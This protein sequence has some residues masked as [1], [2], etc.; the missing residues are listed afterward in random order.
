MMNKHGNQSIAAE[1]GKTLLL[2]MLLALL[3]NWFNPK[4]IPLIR[5]VLQK[6]AVADSVLFGTTLPAR[7]Q[8]REKEQD[9]TKEESAQSDRI[10][11]IAPL[12]Q[13]ALSNLDSMKKVVAI[14]KGDELPII[15]FSQLKRLID[16]HHG[17]LIDARN[18]DEYARGYIEGARNVPYLEVEQHFEEL[19]QIPQ[20]TLVIIYCNNP[21]CPLGRSLLSFMKQMDF[22][23]LILFDGGYD[24][25]EK[26]MKK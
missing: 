24:A 25:W 22:K 3:Y 8:T 16:M 19:T 20:D 21:E 11:V 14:P 1:L 23:N 26:E 2:A 18:A 12:H 9:S 4:G 15:T 13:R 10:P 6:N 5:K 7:N 17:V